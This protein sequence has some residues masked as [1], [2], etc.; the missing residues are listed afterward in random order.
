MQREPYG[1]AGDAQ[2][3][4]DEM[5]KTKAQWREHPPLDSHD[6]DA[7]PARSEAK[8]PRRARRGR[9]TNAVDHDE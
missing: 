3:R 8:R 6:E 2:H 7:T 1:V 9:R 4:F 5:N